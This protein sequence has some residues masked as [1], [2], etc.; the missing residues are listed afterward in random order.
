MGC[1]AHQLFFCLPHIPKQIQSVKQYEKNSS[2]I[3]SGYSHP[4]VLNKES[5]GRTAT[6]SH[7]YIIIIIL[8]HK[9]Q[10]TSFLG[11]RFSVASEAELSCMH[12]CVYHLKQLRVYK[13][14][15]LS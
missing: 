15:V 7:I 11:L 10:K 3:N 13:F 9:G 8:T 4:K 2:K 1:T 6:N 5:I 12:V 14:Q